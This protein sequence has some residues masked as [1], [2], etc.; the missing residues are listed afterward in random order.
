M[1]VFESEV[2]NISSTRRSRAN[3]LSLLVQIYLTSSLSPLRSRYFGSHDDGKDVC[4]TRAMRQCDTVAKSAAASRVV[5][6]TEK[7]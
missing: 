2:G 5:P 6:V 7:N 1:I 4:E 3:F